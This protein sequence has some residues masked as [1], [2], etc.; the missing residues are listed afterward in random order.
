MDNL[1]P[2]HEAF[3]KIEPRV[4]IAA[5]N[6]ILLLTCSGVMYLQ[7]QLLHSRFDDVDAGPE[8]SAGNLHK[9]DYCRT[10]AFGFLWFFVLYV[11][12]TRSY[13]RNE[14]DPLLLCQCL[15]HCTGA[16]FITGIIRLR[17]SLTECSLLNATKK[18]DELMSLFKHP[19]FAGLKSSIHR[20]KRTIGSNPIFGGLVFFVFLASFSLMTN[21]PWLRDNNPWLR[22]IPRLLGLMIPL[23]LLSGLIGRLRRSEHNPGRNEP[24]VWIWRLFSWIPFFYA[25]FQLLGLIRLFTAYDD[26]VRAVLTDEAV[27]VG[28]ILSQVV[29]FCFKVPLL[30]TLLYVTYRFIDDERL[31]ANA[32][33]A[34]SKKE[35]EDAKRN[36]EVSLDRVAHD[37]RSW[38]LQLANYC[39]M[40]LPLGKLKV[41]RSCEAALK[42][43]HDD[44]LI[45]ARWS[46]GLENHNTTL[47]TVLKNELVPSKVNI[48]HVLQSL[49]EV[50]Q[51]RYPSF[52]VTVE[53]SGSLATDFRMDE[54]RVLQVL[55]N[56]LDNS[57]KYSKVDSPVKIKV[58][59]DEIGD[60]RHFICEIIDEGPGFP[61][62]YLAKDRRAFTQGDSAKQGLGIGLFVCDLVLASMGGDLVPDNWV[63]GD[64]SGAS[65]K[66]TIVELGLDVPDRPR[67]AK[68]KPVDGRVRILVVDDSVSQREQ[69]KEAMKLASNEIE[70]D[71]KEAESGEAAIQIWDQH[72]AENKRPPFDLLLI[73]TEMQGQL[74]GPET[75]KILTEN[76]GLDNAT[77]VVG[78]TASKND[79]RKR[80]WE[81]TGYELEEKGPEFI[82]RL[83][84]ALSGSEYRLY[85]GASSINKK[86]ELE[87][88]NSATRLK[89]VKEQFLTRVRE[90][91]AEFHSGKWADLA[92]SAHRAINEFPSD[93]VRQIF[94]DIENG[95]KSIIDPNPC[96]AQKVDVALARLEAIGISL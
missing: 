38:S 94:N 29:N 33:L 60:K 67:F 55:G 25:L 15:S 40:F 85:E 24:V 45:V 63:D 36:L 22:A 65:V 26:S 11:V 83:I 30:L 96:N 90:M 20:F 79:P 89:N 42:S 27:R 78:M 86:S 59:V 56:L 54:G 43:L 58:R 18:P 82:P 37:M 66:V 75:A 70:F 21:L 88:A 73:D 52:K 80:A 77:Q 91:R 57:R 8:K 46:R 13:I 14:K 3:L 71:I 4:P 35:T 10:F 64:R 9:Y 68:V 44:I 6:A 48:D 62:G 5:A 7:W 19:C 49:I 16:C 61:S 95:A 74:T 17:K 53:R 92:I 28:D 50:N 69:M 87:I 76:H 23:L 84:S 39:E 41:A 72:R 12:R 2:F 34:K 1:Q 32:L 47:T 81:T 31:E 93:G 51:A